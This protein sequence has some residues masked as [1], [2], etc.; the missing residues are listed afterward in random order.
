M[1]FNSFEF[2]GF[3]LAVCFLYYVLPK[4]ARA[5][6]MAVASLG[7][8]AL[9][10]L[11]LTAF[12]SVYILFVYTIGIA[13]SKK[14][15]KAVVFLSIVLA[16]L[17]LL[18]CKY[19]NFG[20]SI[21]DKVASLFKLS[22]ATHVITIVA[23]LGISYFTFKSVG[24]LVDVYKGKIK[25]ESD[26]ITFFAYI[27]FFPEMLT[28]PIDR[29]DNLLVQLKEGGPKRWSDLER[30]VLLLLFGFFE[31][32]CIADRLG[33][34]V[35][36]VYSNLRSYS[37]VVV[38]L[39]I[40]FYSIQ[41]YMDFAGCTHMALGVGKALGFDLPENFKEPYMATSVQEF[42]QSWHMSL[43]GWLKEYIYI[44]LGG[45][46]KGIFRKYLNMMVVFFVSGLWHG[47]G[48]SFIVWGCLNGLLQIGGMLLGKRKQAL[49]NALG[50]KE[51][52]EGLRWWKRI[53]VFILM[54]CTWVF[55][56]AG[57]LG[58]AI[59]V[60]RRAACRL[61]PW[62]L[63]D[64][65]LFTLG[66]NEKNFHLLLLLLIFVAI[67]DYTRVRGFKP[68]EWAISAHWIFKCVVFLALL[69]TVIIFGIYGTAY[70]ASSFIY[71]QF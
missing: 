6:L 4:K 54:S 12:L 39:A 52:S 53:G 27:S 38:M 23:P 32:M 22:N 58:F 13:F 14:K 46:R 43:M 69:F 35:D 24:Y 28:G 70:D 17:P 57:S 31:K 61:N 67:F 66:L 15:G 60:F 42:W 56:R 64:G 18:V 40:A 1:T 50:I 71:M 20:L 29:S 68:L 44:P 33:I 36:H 10:D 11:R 3:F 21:L 25:A 2:L 19:T 65:T 49:Y 26:F 16:L 59:S 8:Y 63:F 55:F 62:C 45:N 5:V 41:I 47:A 7:F 37:G 51:T 9:Y 34:V 30:G 48:F